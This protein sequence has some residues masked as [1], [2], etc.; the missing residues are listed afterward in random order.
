MQK[1]SQMASEEEKQTVVELGGESS[2]EWPWNKPEIV[3]MRKE[4]ID[5][6]NSFGRESEDFLTSMTVFQ[7]LVQ[8]E[9]RI[10]HGSIDHYDSKDGA[11]LSNILLRV[12]QF[13]LYQTAADA[14]SIHDLV[15]NLD[16]EIYVPGQNS[17]DD[18]EQNIYN[19]IWFILSL[20][21]D[22]CLMAEHTNWL[23]G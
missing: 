13:V 14:L 22:W 7:E 1:R 16:G 21:E 4:A 23:S 9:M 10:I 3:R 5:L 19:D 20:L 6:T 15:M 11:T 17:V 12:D 18:L 2:I 8:S